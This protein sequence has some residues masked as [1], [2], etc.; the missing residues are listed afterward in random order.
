MG[1]EGREVCGVCDGWKTDDD[2]MCA[3][4]KGA[5]LHVREQRTNDHYTITKPVRINHSGYGV[6]AAFEVHGHVKCIVCGN[7]SSK[8]KLFCTE[9]STVIVGMS[10]AIGPLTPEQVKNV[11]DGILNVSTETW[12]VFAMMADIGLQDLIMSQLEEMHGKDR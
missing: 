11:M 10:R 5:I 2:F 8:D 7:Q 9:C 1:S 6:P 3:A 4:C 12:E